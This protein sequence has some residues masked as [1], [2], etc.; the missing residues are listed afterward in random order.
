MASL[1]N[2]KTNLALRRRLRKTMT[3]PEQRLW[4]YLR[5]GQLGTKFR[6]QHGIGPYVVDFYCPELRLVIEVDGDSHYTES[7]IRHDR[8]RNDFLHQSGLST[9][10]FTNHD[11]MTQLPAVLASLQEY[12][13]AYRKRLTPP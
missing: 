5:H 13:V 7:G 11:I 4:H 6:R 3:E 12:L 2:D 10:R 1:F 8:Q 9:L